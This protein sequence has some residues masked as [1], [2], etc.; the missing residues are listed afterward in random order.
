MNTDA[1]ALAL[2]EMNDGDGKV[3]ELDGDVDDPK[4]LTASDLD[5]CIEAVNKSSV[6]ASEK[7]PLV[8]QLN[9]LRQ[10]KSGWAPR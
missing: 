8:K 5:T 2:H 3:P 1:I 4:T 7:R 6:K 9:E 10:M